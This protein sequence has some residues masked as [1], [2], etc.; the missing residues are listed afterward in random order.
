MSFE[1]QCPKGWRFI[2]DWG[3]G[4]AYGQIAGGLR[5]LIDCEVKED[6]N[7]WIHV[8]VSRKSWTPSHEDMALAKT[9]FIGPDRYAY[10]IYPPASKYVNIHPYCLHLWARADEGD[11]RVLPEFSEVVEEIGR[12]I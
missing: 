5:V 8:S 11:G 4:R 9:A 6:G 7:E 12:T 2:M 1:F 10:A 3:E